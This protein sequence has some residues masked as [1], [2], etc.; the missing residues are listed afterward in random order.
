[1]AGQSLVR[2]WPAMLL[3]AIGSLA[4]QAAAGQQAP[5]GAPGQESSSALSTLT[6]ERVERYLEGRA[7]CRGCHEAFRVR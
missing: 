4:A 5:S 3:F 7:A 2:G 1:M 6:V